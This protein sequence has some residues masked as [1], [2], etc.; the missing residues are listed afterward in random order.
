MSVRYTGAG[1]REPLGLPAGRR[2]VYEVHNRV[3]GKRM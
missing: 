1:A 2:L 3:R